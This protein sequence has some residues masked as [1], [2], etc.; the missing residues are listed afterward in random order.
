[1][2]SESSVAA[3]TMNDL[4]RFHGMNLAPNI[5]SFRIVGAV[6]QA[7]VR[8]ALADLGSRWTRR[9]VK[10]PE[11]PAPA[12][13]AAP[14]ILFYDLPGAKQSLF[15]FGYP[16][17][18]R[19]DHDFYSATVMNYILGGG[20]FASRLTQ[21][22]REGKGYTYGIR[23][24]FDGGVRH[25]TFQISSG[26]RSNATLEAAELTRSILSDYGT[27]FS[28]ADLGVT[29]SALTKSRLRAFETLGAKLSYLGAIADYGL[30][31]DFPRREQAIVDGL[32]QERVRELAGRF[33]RPGEMTYVIVGDAETQA[34]RL[35]A[36][37]LGAPVMVKEALERL[38]R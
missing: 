38:D 16:G 30:P 21:Q 4:K 20:G 11:H 34:K 1:L 25:G 7:E 3:L 18:K 24:G 31:I 9:E 23:S 32:T 10:I 5:A 15:A 12:A 36:L 17:P 13:P 2:G 27:T 8:T 6:N 33:V 14:R 35:E 29:K 22:L 26:V 37:G 28:E 19:A